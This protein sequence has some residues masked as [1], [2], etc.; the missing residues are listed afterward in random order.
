[1]DARHLLAPKTAKDRRE[2]GADQRRKAKFDRHELHP[3]G[4]HAV[5]PAGKQQLV[6]RGDD[7]HREIA[8]ELAVAH[9][10]NPHRIGPRR[11]IAAANAKQHREKQRKR[12]EHMADPVRQAERIDLVAAIKDR[13]GQPGPAEEHAERRPAASDAV[14]QRDQLARDDMI[15][16]I[17]FAE[18]DDPLQRDERITH[19]AQIKRDQIGL[20]VGKHGNRRWVIAKMATMI[21]FGQR[22]LNRTVPA[23]DDENL[24]LYARD[25]AQ[26]LANLADL[27][28]LIVKDIRTP[29][30]E[31]A[32][33]R[34]QRPVAGRPGIGK[35]RDAAHDSPRRRLA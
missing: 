5:G 13:V 4:H 10:R 2:Q 35:K 15:G 7:E 22:S 23:I 30:A 14:G 33:A 19:R 29:R 34:E 28:H 8:V 18:L 3:A 27:F 12:R 21:E 11:Q 24:R 25:G 9:K 32:H 1:M 26:R 6:E 20:A 17:R 16:Q 31:T